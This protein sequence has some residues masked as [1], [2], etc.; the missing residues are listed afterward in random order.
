MIKICKVRE[1]LD[2][3]KK[4]VLLIGHTQHYQE[5][6]TIRKTIANIKED[7]FGFVGTAW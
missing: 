5:I 7:S 6:Y 1:R 3:H 4:V 2:N